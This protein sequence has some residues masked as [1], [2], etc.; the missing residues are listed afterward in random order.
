MHPLAHPTLQKYEPMILGCTYPDV[1]RKMLELRA[2]R[3]YDADELLGLAFNG[4]GSL[5][6]ASVATIRQAVCRE[7]AILD[8]LSAMRRSATGY[9]F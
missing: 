7:P 1:I 6:G 2:S 3:T 9:G 5:P 4:I 8:K